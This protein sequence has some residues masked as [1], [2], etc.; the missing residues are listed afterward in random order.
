MLTAVLYGLLASS[1]FLIGS[2]IGCFASPPRRLVASVIAFGSG[3]LVSALT[4]ELT[5]EAFER[6][7]LA[8]TI[9]GFPS[10][11]SVRCSTGYP[12]TPR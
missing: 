11:W 1:S 4:F 2:V 7:S 5:E 12:R 10:C 8:H 3:V 6:G 9:A